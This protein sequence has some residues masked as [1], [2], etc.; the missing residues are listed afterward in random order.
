MALELEEKVSLLAEGAHFDVCSPHHTDA[1]APV[2]GPAQ[3]W[4][5]WIYPAVVSGGRAVRLFKVLLTNVCDNSCLYCACRQGQDCRRSAFSPEELVR[6]FLDLHARGQADGLFLSSA[7]ARSG[8]RTMARTLAAVE[9]LRGRHDYRGYIHLKLLP[10]AERAAVER[11]MQ[12]ADR[13]SINLEAPGPARLAALS[14]EKDFAALEERL[15]W[16]AD[17]RRERGAGAPAGITTQ[18]VVGAA[19]ESDAELLATAGRLYRQYNLARV[20]YSAFRPLAGTP[21]AEAPATPAA[22]ELRLY[23]ADF[24]LHRY[25]FRPEELVLDAAGNLPLRQDPKM[26]WAKAHPEAFP[27]EINSADP[28]QLLRVPGI[29]PRGVKLILAARREGKLRTEEQLRALGVSVGRAGPHLLL[30]GRR[31]HREA[32]RQLALWDDAEDT[33]AGSAPS[34]R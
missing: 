15:R 18:F 6:A 4:Q 2:A 11:A 27:L 24:L 32:P 7:L 3:N 23:Q 19:G 30:D 31:L 21:L 9:L 12:L 29:G 1:S 14:R 13:V 28:A 8:A 10:G 25:G 17:L 34:G 22:R 20:Y 5:R 26:A 16:A 33:D